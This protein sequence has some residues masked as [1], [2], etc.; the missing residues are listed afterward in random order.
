MLDLFS[1]LDGLFSL[2]IMKFLM[3]INKDWGLDPIPNPQTIIINESGILLFL[4]HK[5]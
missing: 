2:K 4:F 1:F 5:I 3:N